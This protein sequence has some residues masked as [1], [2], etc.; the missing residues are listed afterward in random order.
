MFHSDSPTTP[1]RPRRLIA[2]ALAFVLVSLLLLAAGP[3]APVGEA[4]KGASITIEADKQ[5]VKAGENV[6][7]KI[8]LQNVTNATLNGVA[9]PDGKDK[10]EKKVLVCATTTY[11]V[12][13]M[14]KDGGPKISQALTITASGT[15]TKAACASSAP[16]PTATPNPLP[17][18]V[19]VSLTASQTSA[20]FNQLVQVDYVIKNVGTEAAG[21]SVTRAYLEDKAMEGVLQLASL[22]P[23]ESA[24]GTS[25]WDVPKDANQTLTIKVVVDADK[26]VAESDETNNVRTVFVTVG[27]PKN[28]TIFKKVDK[29]DQ[30]V[31]EL[32]QV[33]PDLAVNSITVVQWYDPQTPTAEGVRVEYTFG[34][35]GQA[36]A[37]K[38]VIALYKNGQLDFKE[39]AGS[40]RA[41]E[42]TSGSV[43][44]WLRDSGGSYTYSLVL[45]PDNQIAERTK[46]IT[47]RQPASSWCRA[48]I[49]WAASSTRPIS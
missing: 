45:D 4:A 3:A 48:Q 46:P 9:L 37:E 20:G 26:Q 13:A 30:R 29:L 17:D 38:V 19:I 21:L 10:V 49:H 28:P 5:I 40:L 42:K 25:H 11:T 6:N 35:L 16:A 39:P 18:L 24:S 44:S 43:T 1:A 2:A 7:L 31:P 23:G 36:P 14:P 41:G 12:A 34:N 22:A 32:L 47:R 27:T 8:K 33:K 15:T